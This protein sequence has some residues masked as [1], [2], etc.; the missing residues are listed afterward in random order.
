MKEISF[1]DLV[2]SETYFIQSPVKTGNGKQKG[3]FMSLRETFP[4]IYWA[5]FEDVEDT[6]GDSGYS[7][8]HR[9]FRVDLC[10][11]YVYNKDWIMKKY[12]RNGLLKRFITDSRIKSYEMH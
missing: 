5:V 12:L 1:I 6:D 11:F 2:R 3:R 10:S 8:G 7:I 4:G 9:L